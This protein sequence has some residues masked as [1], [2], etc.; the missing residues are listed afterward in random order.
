MGNINGTAILIPDFYSA[1]WVVGKHNG[2]YEAL[3]QY[4]EPFRVWRDN[5]QD[6]QFDYH[7]VEY[8]DVTGLN[9]HTESLVNETE[10]VGAYSAGCQVRQFDRDHFMFMELVSDPPA[11]G[12]AS[13]KPHKGFGGGSTL[14]SIPQLC[15]DSRVKGDKADVIVSALRCFDPDALFSSIKTADKEPLDFNRSETAGAQQKEHPTH[16]VVGDDL[17]Q[18]LTLGRLH[19]KV[20]VILALEGDLWHYLT[21]FTSLYSALNNASST[22]P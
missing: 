21:S 14:R 4:K 10:K 13:L 6:G 20:S 2:K 8:R 11:R 9:M 15:H 3:V 7:G 1:C 5:D 12:R 17:H 18:P 22:T 16:F 19:E